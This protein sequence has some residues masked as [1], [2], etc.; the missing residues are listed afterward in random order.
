MSEHYVYQFYF[1]LTPGAPDEAVHALQDLATG[2]AARASDLAAF[3]LGGFMTLPDMTS[4]RPQQGSPV[5]VWET[6]HA[7]NAG[8]SFF[9]PLPK[10]GVRFSFLMHDDLYAN[11]GYILP[12]AVFDLVGDHGLFGM[13]F[14]ETNRL[15]TTL[16][17]KEFDDLIVQSIEAPS[18]AYPLA[19]AAARNPHAYLK[20]WT[21]ATASG[22]SLG[23][24]HRFTPDDRQQFFAEADRMFGPPGE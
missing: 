8:N 1:G 19:P 3:R 13:M 12:F 20:D 14:D 10:H 24:F 2:K 5:V 23:E 18:M 6:G 22:F 11:G 16:Y 15:T 21:P 9:A 4:F 17:F 7:D